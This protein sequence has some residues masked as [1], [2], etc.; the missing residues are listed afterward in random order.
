VIEKAH[1]D[2]GSPVSEADDLLVEMRLAHGVRTICFMRSRRGESK[3]IK[4][5]ASRTAREGDK[6]DS[7]PIAPSGGLHPSKQRREIEAQLRLGTCCRGGK[8]DALS[9]GNSRGESM[10]PSASNTR[11]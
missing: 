10:R 7:R 1:D 2:A 5:F 4:R 11:T 9:S 8:P 3:M 6:G